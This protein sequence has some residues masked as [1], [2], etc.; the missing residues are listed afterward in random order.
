MNFNYSCIGFTCLNG[1]S[2]Y[3]AWLPL[4]SQRNEKQEMGIDTVMNALDSNA[5]TYFIEAMNCVNGPPTGLQAAAK[6]A[7]AQ[8]FFYLPSEACYRITPTV[9]LE[10]QR[11]KDTIKK[12]DHR[13]WAMT[14]ISAVRPLPDPRRLSVRVAQ[15]QAHHK[16]KEDCKV[17]AECELCEIK[18]LL[19]SDAAF[20][21]R[22]GAQALGV[23]VTTPEDYWRQLGIP[24]GTP[25]NR[26][27]TADNP[28]SGTSW[29]RA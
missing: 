23:R 3:G 24:T 15:L 6:K 5:M 26:V 22:L 18:T 12:D 2:Q 13:S 11:I 19:T 7:L 20:I 9:D 1:W 29:W 16:K 21:K 10:Y 28:L 27:P 14:H 4:Q 17:L 25:P 8:V